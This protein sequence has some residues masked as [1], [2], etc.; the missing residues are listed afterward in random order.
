[1]GAELSTTDEDDD[2]PDV[3]QRGMRLLKSAQEH[4]G[5]IYSK[6]KDDLHFLSDD[7]HAHWDELDVKARKGKNRP[8]LQIDQLTQFINQVS[9][10]VRMNTPS[11]NI[12]PSDQIANSETAEIIKGRIKDIE[13]TSAA[14]DAYDHAVNSAIK[15]SIGYIR[16]DHKFKDE[17]SFDQEVLIQ[18]VVNP[19]AVWIDPESIEPDGSDAMWAAVIDDMS[20]KE[21]KRQFP[22]KEVKSFEAGCEDRD[23]DGDDFRVKVAEFFEVEIEE[24]EIGLLPTGETVPVQEGVQYRRTRILEKRTVKRYKLSGADV[25]EE[26]IF[27]GIYVPIIPV[28]GEE[29]W[30]NGERKLNSLIRRSKDAQRMFNFW[31]STEAE[32]LMKSPK[33]I[34]IAA[35]GTTED[36]SEDWLNPEKAAVLRYKPTMAAN[37]QFLPPP[38]LNPPPQIPAGIVNA[39]M[40]AQNDIRSTMG[41]YNAYLGQQ[42]NEN[43][44]VAINARKIEGDRAAFHFGDNLVRSITQV[45]RVIVSMLPVID[46]TPKLVRVIGDDGETKLV[47]ING[48]MAEG[49]QQTFDLTRGSYGV[50]VTTGN[51]LPTMR[52]E[53]ATILQDLVTKAPEMLTVVG[54][55]LFKYQD[56]P[57]ASAVA[58]RL[59]KLLRPEILAGEE[60]NADPQVMALQN[61]NQ[62]LKQAIQQLQAE[63]QSKQAELQMKQQEIALKAQSEASDNAN[64]RAKNELAFMSLKLDEQKIISDINIKEQ[65]LAL[66]AR[67]LS[68]KEAEAIIAAQQR[69]AGAVAQPQ[70]DPTEGF[71]GVENG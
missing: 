18:R 70:H 38:S 40:A 8:V 25:L 59:K 54:D 57:G 13:N 48:M 49:Q 9:N 55:L 2:A 4:W 52:S 27:P 32:L 19:F 26:T 67:E 56:F 21:F 12:I 28:Y 62:Q 14:D 45:G 69:T 43:S 17:S 39:S 42:S 11:I 51:S 60:G 53:A 6:A 16:V 20:A 71:N 24:T 23:R 29:A 36:F 10:N 50:I 7:P 33:A 44:G 22:G 3:V 46:D 66:K 68:I 37:G 30:E 1:M 15:C 35:V 34:A 41:L 65:E 5:D 64:E 47:G 61:E 58:A 63:M 31:K